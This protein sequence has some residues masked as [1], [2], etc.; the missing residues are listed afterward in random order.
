MFKGHACFVVPALE[1]VVLGSS[2]KSCHH[3]SASGLLS[4][5]TFVVFTCLL[6]G[7][8]Y[9]VPYLWVGFL[10]LELMGP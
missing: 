7:H 9:K 10:A 5:E 6:K 2:H 3:C 1:F 4:A 8:E